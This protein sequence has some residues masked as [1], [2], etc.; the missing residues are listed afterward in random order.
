M[1]E[2]TRRWFKQ[3]NQKTFDMHILPK[4]RGKPTTY[5][6]L[7]TFEGAS[8]IWMLHNVLTHRESRAVCCDPH[9]QTSKLSEQQMEVIR[10]RCVKNLEEWQHRCKL[11]RGCSAEV[12]RKMCSKGL[13]GITKNSCDLI[14]IDGNHIAPYVYDDAVHCLHLCKQGGWLLFDDVENDITKNNHVKQG[15]EMF[16]ADYGDKVKRV[17]KHRYCECY[18]V[19]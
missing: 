11:V 7:G 19:I 12:L 13:E 6:E 2:F 10:Q 9:L 18:E 15:L 3:R 16:L 17:F 1:P 4:F 5:L 14:Y 8:V